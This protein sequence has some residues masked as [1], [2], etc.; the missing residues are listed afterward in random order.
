MIKVDPNERADINDVVSYCEKQL[1][2][3][4]KHKVLEES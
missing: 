3:I 1:S 2:A 4:N